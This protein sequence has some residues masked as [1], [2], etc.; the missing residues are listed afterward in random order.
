MYIYMYKEVIVSPCKWNYPI[1]TMLEPSFLL[2]QFL[3]H[4]LPS[5][6]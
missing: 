5:L 3:L 1:Q 4:L 2:D 6:F